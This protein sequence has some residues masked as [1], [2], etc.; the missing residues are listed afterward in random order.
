MYDDNN[1]Y[2]PVQLNHKLNDMLSE[3]IIRT[4]MFSQWES[5]LYD[6]ELA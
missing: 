6:G 5:T 1:E 2:F 3:L 4:I